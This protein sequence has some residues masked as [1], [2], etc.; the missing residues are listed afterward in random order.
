MSDNTNGLKEL[1]NINISRNEIR[2]IAK[3]IIREIVEKEIQSALKELNVNQIIQGKL[4][5]VD[6][7]LDAISKKEIEAKMQKEFWSV[8][9]KIN[10]TI[11]TMILEKL[12]GKELIPNVYLKLSARDIET[13]YDY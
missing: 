4:N 13:E 1:L 5:S 8:Q 2:D 9:N 6:K 11:R 10:Q 7:K 3:E 12:N